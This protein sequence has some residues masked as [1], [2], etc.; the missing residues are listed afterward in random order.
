MP[1]EEKKEQEKKGT[2]KPEEKKGDAT[3]DVQIR[4]KRLE[5]KHTKQNEERDAAHAAEIEKINAKNDE[6]FSKLKSTL[7]LEKEKTVDDLADDVKTE[8]ARS[9]RILRKS[10]FATAA[11]DAGL[12]IDPDDAFALLRKSDGELVVDKDDRVHGIDAAVAKLK[13]RIPDLFG[14]PT[15]PEKKAVGTD[16]SGKTGGESDDDGELD[17][18]AIRG[19]AAA[20]RKA[21]PGLLRGLA[22]TLGRGRRP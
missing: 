20:I 7:G 10:R 11:K 13:E 17:L 3:S 18:D 5:E 12:K 1:E 2:E 19:D 4:I 21:K 16:T 9:D 8:R 14:S 22:E 15:P 6:R